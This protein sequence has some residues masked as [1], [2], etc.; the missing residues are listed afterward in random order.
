[1][2]VHE[3]YDWLLAKSYTDKIIINVTPLHFNEVPVDEQQKETICI[4]IESDCYLGK[5]V[6]WDD[7]SCFY[8]L[9]DIE[10]ATTILHN[11]IDFLSFDELVSIYDG[12]IKYSLKRPK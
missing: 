3:F 7:N 4:D 6:V 8:E 9:M 12:F 5:F 1:M 11:R 10:T 2:I